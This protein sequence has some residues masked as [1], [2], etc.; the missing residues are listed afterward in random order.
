MA[1]FLQHII[2]GLSQGGTYALI[3][4]GYTMVFGILQLINFA[5]G[6]VYMIGAFVGYYSSKFFGEELSQFWMSL[7]GKMAEDGQTL[8]PTFASS[9]LTAMT[10]ILIAMLVC[11][12]IGF[13]VER[14][15]YRPLR[16]A[17]RINLLITAV[18]VSLLFQYSGQLFFGSD[19]KAYP[20]LFS[21]LD[22]WTFGSEEE[23]LVINPIQVTVLTSSII[24]MLILRH[25][26]FHT[27][28][29]RAMRAVSFNH[30]LAS[31]MGIP[32]NLIVSATFMM[33]SALAGAAGVM[34]GLTYPKVEPLMGSMPGLKAFCAAVLGG[35]GNVTGAVLG[36]F[37]L[38]LAEA[39]LSGYA[40]P[41]YRD[42]L[43]F[44]V[45]IVILLVKPSG[46]LGV[47]RT[48]KV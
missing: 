45:L 5:H 44:G 48:E 18:G 33:G 27:R 3:A 32:T 25:V 6:E 15:A 13:L 23:S 30:D 43:A 19:P 9:L 41:T 4:L 1:E 26:I 37:I 38:G 22:V 34:V 46:I 8:I 40:M 7:A 12:C 35:I 29:G 2:N 39:L 16:S 28:L 42:A 11:A 10:I 14:F 24:L 21:D 17:P 36:S 47:H 31:L 20:D